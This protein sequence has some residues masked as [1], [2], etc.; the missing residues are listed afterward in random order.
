MNARLP[1]HLQWPIPEFDWSRDF[2]GWHDRSRD[3]RIV[4]ARKARE[5]AMQAE[6]AE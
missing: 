2:C 4:K 1:R 3:P 5:A 6:A